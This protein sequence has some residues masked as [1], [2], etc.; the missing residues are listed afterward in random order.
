MALLD[1]IVTSLVSLAGWKKTQRDEDGAYHFRLE[2]GLDFILFSPDDRLCIMRAEVADV[3]ASGPDREEMLRTVA[4][5]QAGICRTRAS[6]VALERP[7]QSL[8]KSVPVS[9]DKLILYRAAELTAAQDVF[10]SAVRSFLNDLA[11]WKDASGG[12]QREHGEER[13]FFGMPGMFPGG[14]Y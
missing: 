6:I 13:S 11:W 4:K 7:G 2:K 5:R 1:N 8:L 14:I 10:N 12:G 3:P 9:G